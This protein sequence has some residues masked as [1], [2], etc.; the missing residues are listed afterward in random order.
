MIEVLDAIWG[1]KTVAMLDVWSFDH[2]IS[3]TSIG[4]SVKKENH[5]HFSKHYPGIQFKQRTIIRFDLILVLFLAYLWETIEHYLEEGLLGEV[6]AYWFQGV[7]FL[8]NR[9]IADPLLLVLGY[10][11]ACKFPKLV[12][13]ARVLSAIWL[14]VHIF[15]FPH[16]MYLHEVF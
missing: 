5:R 3:G 1:V 16:S 15:V 10:Y 12:I 7:E 13:P 9:F 14:F 8:P 11:L 2:L 6:V 4:N